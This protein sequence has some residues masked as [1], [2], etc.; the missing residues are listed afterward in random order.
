MAKK[1]V[2]VMLTLGEINHLHALLH[3]EQG[4][5]TYYGNR[6]EHAT[7]QQRLMRLLSAKASE[8]RGEQS[9]RKDGT[10]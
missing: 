9:E 7:R 2:P 4:E 3:D 5:G 6:E 8:A 10:A 1:Y